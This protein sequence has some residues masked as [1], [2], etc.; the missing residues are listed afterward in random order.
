MDL[1][2]NSRFLRKRVKVSVVATV[3]ATVNIIL[4]VCYMIYVSNVCVVPLYRNVCLV[5]FLCPYTHKVLCNH[6]GV[7]VFFLTSDVKADQAV[8]ICAIL[9]SS[10]QNS[11]HL[12][13]GIALF[14]CSPIQ[15]PLKPRRVVVNI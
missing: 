2:L 14:H 6:V 7:L 3:A 4:Q 11:Y 13:E 9:I 1:Q 5:V 15:L 12:A 10:F 8:L